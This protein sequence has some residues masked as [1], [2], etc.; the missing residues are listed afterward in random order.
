M[1]LHLASIWFKPQLK[2]KRGQNSVIKVLNNFKHDKILTDED[3]ENTSK[4]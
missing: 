2:S 1:G 4:P 3:N